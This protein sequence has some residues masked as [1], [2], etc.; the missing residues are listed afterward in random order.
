MKTINYLLIAGTV[1]G[2]AIG[3]FYAGKYSNQTGIVE[4][5]GSVTIIV[6]DEKLIEKYGDEM[7]RGLLRIKVPDIYS[8]LLIPGLGQIFN[9]IDTEAIRK[10]M[11][12]IEEERF[13]EDHLEK[14]LI[15]C[16][17]M[18]EKFSSFILELVFTI[19]KFMLR[20]CEIER[21][22]TDSW[23]SVRCWRIFRSSS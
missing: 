9:E 16:V 15:P 18:T 20:K 12:A 3:G 8:D 23:F 2:V 4:T 19:L 10:K 14:N 22:L 11:K 7:V 13:L 6:S 1:I 5:N 17:L 21:F